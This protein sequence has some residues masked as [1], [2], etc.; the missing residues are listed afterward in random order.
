MIHDNYNSRYRL[1]SKELFTKLVNNL[2][3]H[4]YSYFFV[5]ESWL[6]PRAVN[7]VKAM[8]A[9]IY[10]GQNPADKATEREICLMINRALAIHNPSINENEEH[11]RGVIEYILREKISNDKTKSL[12]NGQRPFD[13]AT[14]F[15]MAIMFTR[16]VTGNDKLSELVLTREQV[17]EII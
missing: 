11:F 8:K 2:V 16:A 12:Y 4:G 7:V 13:L 17:A 10:N 1:A 3:I 9:K 5:K 6:T 15:E 14:Q